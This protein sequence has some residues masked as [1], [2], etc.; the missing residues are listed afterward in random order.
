MPQYEAGPPAVELDAA[1]RLI[2]RDRDD[3][4]VR[5]RVHQ[6]DP[7]V[8]DA[9]SGEPVDHYVYRLGCGHLINV[10]LTP[11]PEGT[12]WTYC[13]QPGC[14]RERQVVEHLSD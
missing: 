12:G 9:R 10:W 13:E 3:R 7:L 4:K 8:R 2:E 14:E 11:L 6:L 1:L 5:R